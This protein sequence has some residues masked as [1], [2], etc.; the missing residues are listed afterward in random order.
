MTATD[1]LT[2]GQ[3]VSLP[4]E[5]GDEN[6]PRFEPNDAWLREATSTEQKTAMWRWFATRFEEP[7][8]AMPNDGN[9]NVLF[10]DGGPF[11]ADELLHERFDDSVG[12]ETIN[13]FVRSLQR[14]AGNEWALKPLDRFGG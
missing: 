11:M 3:L 12:Q 8:T 4:A 13:E 7:N 5:A 10:T 9:G 6:K 2:D 1:Q 14:E